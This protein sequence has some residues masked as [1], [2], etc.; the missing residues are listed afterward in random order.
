MNAALRKI[1]ARLRELAK[2]MEENTPASRAQ[3]EEL[4]HELRVSANQ[5]GAQ[6]EMIEQ[7]LVD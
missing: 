7:G 6:A 4:T 1:E 2:S 3:V 5:I